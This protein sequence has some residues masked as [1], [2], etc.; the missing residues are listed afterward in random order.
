MPPDHATKHAGRVSNAML[1]AFYNKTNN[2]NYVF[3]II[4]NY[5]SLYFIVRSMAFVDA[6]EVQQTGEEPITYTVLDIGSQRGSQ[7]LVE[8]SGYR[9]INAKAGRASLPFYVLVPLLHQEAEHAQL[10]ANL[11]SSRK[12]RKYQNTT[13]KNFKEECSNS[14]KDMRKQ[15]LCLLHPS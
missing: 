5:N 12:L 10:Q 4:I 15:K 14:G 13:Y 6:S 3:Y 9:C 8:S 1:Q 2:N 7:L 11:L